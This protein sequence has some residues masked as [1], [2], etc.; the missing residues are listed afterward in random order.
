M[1]SILDFKSC[2]FLNPMHF[3]N[4]NLEKLSFPDKFFHNNLEDPSPL[5][6]HPNF[7]LPT[8]SLEHQVRKLPTKFD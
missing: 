1:E 7:N 8:L 5:L 2:L 4:R 3:Q 6:L